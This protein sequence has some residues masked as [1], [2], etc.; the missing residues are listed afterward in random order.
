[1]FVGWGGVTFWAV[2]VSYDPVDVIHSR[3]NCD[4]KESLEH[5]VM[6]QCLEQD[7]FVRLSV[8]LCA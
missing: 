3:L 8:C 1:M 7:H 5:H 4:A 2:E 6:A